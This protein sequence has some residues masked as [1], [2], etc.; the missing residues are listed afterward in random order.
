MMQEVAAS[1]HQVR[2]LGLY[3]L[4]LV[5]ACVPAPALSTVTPASSSTMRAVPASLAFM[6]N[7]EAV[8]VLAD[9]IVM[10]HYPYTDRL[11]QAADDLQQLLATLS[12][13]TAFL[14][15][16]VRF[17]VCRMQ[18]RSVPLPY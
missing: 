1:C 9:V 10:A 17:G 11:V 8:M 15:Y 4:L 14:R 18:Q 2:W 5:A 16:W 6:A 13:D 3:L 12:P 7:W